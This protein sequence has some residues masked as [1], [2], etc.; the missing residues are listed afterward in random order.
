[1]NNPNV[2]LAC[3]YLSPHPGNFIP[4]ITALDDY[5]TEKGGRV[6]YAF[7]SR[8][9]CFLWCQRLVKNGKRIYFYGSKSLRNSL[10]FLNRIIKLEKVNVIHTHFEPFDKPSLLIKL[11]HPSIKVIWHL[12]NDFTLGLTQT[13]TPKQ[14]LKDILVNHLITTIA[15]SPHIKTKNGY[16]LINHLADNCPE[17]GTYRRNDDFRT[18]IGVRAEEKLIL[19]FGW[20]KITKGLDTAC[21]MLSYLPDTIRSKCKL[22]IQVYKCPENEDFVKKHCS[23]QEQIIWLEGTDDVF[24]YHMAADIMLSAARSETFA[25]TIMEALAVGTSV[26]STD[27]PGVQWSKDFGNIWF[28][29]SGN[30]EDCARAIV[31]C[32]KEQTRETSMETAVQIRTKLPICRWCEDIYK[33][34]LSEK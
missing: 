20:D 21:E 2:L 15:V 1:M 7:P 30:S 32:L 3:D 34:Y 4:S 17:V 8:C 31:Q 5:V 22:G 12:H 10:T 24:R 27:I 26:V 25:Y 13:K 29:E 28:F 33:I 14:V 9:E 23:Y 11:L 6:V 18:S 19:S 16:V